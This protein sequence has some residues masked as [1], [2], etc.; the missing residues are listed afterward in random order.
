[1]LMLISQILFPLR[2]KRTRAYVPHFQ[3]DNVLVRQRIT[4]VLCFLIMQLELRWQVIAAVLVLALHWGLLQPSR[5][6]T[7][8]FL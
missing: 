2:M 7:A 3:L 5:E 8:H 6:K 1:M 4:Y